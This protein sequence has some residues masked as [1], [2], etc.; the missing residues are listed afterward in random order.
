MAGNFPEI[1]IKIVAGQEAAAPRECG[2]AGPGPAEG[3]EPSGQRSRRPGWGAGSELTQHPAASLGP[4][5]PPASQKCHLKPP[6]LLSVSTAV[7]P[8]SLCHPWGD[9]LKGS[10]RGKLGTVE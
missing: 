3:A 2:R 10:G 7:L 4:A 9:R 8:L 6:R 1:L 5:R